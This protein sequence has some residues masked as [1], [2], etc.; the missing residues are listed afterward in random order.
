MG[1]SLREQLNNPED[2]TRTRPEDESDSGVDP[3]EIQSAR[4]VLLQLSKTTKTLKLYLPNNP[5]YQKFLQELLG[6]FEA[7][8]QEYETLRLQVKQYELLCDGEAVYENADRTESLAFTLFTD[9]IRELT[10]LEGLEREEI[11]SLLE[12]FGHEYDPQNPDD[13][14]VTL[15]WERHFDHV[16][17]LVVDNFVKESTI[18]PKIPPSGEVLPFHEKEKAQVSSQHSS[19]EAGASSALQEVLGPNL[20]EQ[21]LQVFILSD[22]EIADMKQQV[23]EE[24][25]ATPI[26]ILMR[27]ITAILRIERDDKTFSDMVDILDNVM[28]TLMR[29]SDFQNATHTLKLYR[30]L[31]APERSLLESQ[32]LRLKQAIDRAGE[33]QRILEIE[34]TINK[35]E[36]AQIEHLSEFYSCLNKNAVNGL[37][38]LL[39][40]LPQMKMRR[41]ICEALIHLGKNNLDPM[42]RR[43]SDPRW[44]MV[45]NLVYI[46][47]KIGDESVLGKFKRIVDHKEVKVRTE[48][49]HALGGI[50]SAE[51]LELIR[52]LLNDSESSIRILAV[53]SLTRHGHRDSV[54]TL[55]DMIEDPRFSSKDLYEKRE[56]FDALG[57][58]GGDPIVPR[59]EALLKKGG[60]GWF[61]R[62]ADEELG[63]CAVIA[64]RRVGTENAIAVLETGRK[65]SSKVL[66]E[67]CEKSLFELKK[68]KGKQRGQ[69][70]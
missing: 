2:Q 25:N 33:P 62:G 29:R 11:T 13:D 43:L 47:G 52:W 57:R 23:D 3:K 55:E 46:L 59:M 1:D 67:T 24:D 56:I 40:R 37:T 21:A 60:S 64:L 49:I 9:G 44:Y 70:L 65:L 26:K 18:P 48:L 20:S 68:S 66:S 22:E 16:Q 39:G 54:K 12:I 31:M 63:L 4:E 6:R 69:K 5:I 42:V 15:L 61:R 35:L 50:K 51:A 45:R 53:R 28:E 58:L 7:H 32:R 14:M 38:D 8:F 30:E 41:V 19:G 34:S 17:Y 27:I 36:P 10:F